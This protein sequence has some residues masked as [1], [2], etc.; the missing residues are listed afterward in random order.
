MGLEF[1]LGRRMATIIDFEEVRNGW[2]EMPID[3]RVNE[4]VC[5]CW[6]SEL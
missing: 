3:H 2:I 6:E 5:V 1:L 4:V